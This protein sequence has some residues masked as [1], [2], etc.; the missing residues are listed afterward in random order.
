MYISSL[1][2]HF[3]NIPVLE[4]RLKLFHLCVKLK[5]AMFKMPPGHMCLGCKIHH[6]RFSVILILTANSQVCTYQIQV[7][8]IPPRILIGPISPLDDG[9]IGWMVVITVASSKLVTAHTWG[10]EF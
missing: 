4:L 5:Q 10:G 8:S 2:S 9:E 6:S 1:N 7:K 3:D